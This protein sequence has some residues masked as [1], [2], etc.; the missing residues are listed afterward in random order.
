MN[1]WCKCQDFSA[2]LLYESILSIDSR[3]YYNFLVLNS[4]VCV[5]MVFA[6]IQIETNLQSISCRRA[7]KTS[8]MAA[9]YYG[10]KVQSGITIV[11]IYVDCWWQA[12]IAWAI[13]TKN[14]N[15]CNFVFFFKSWWE[16]LDVVLFNHFHVM[17]HFRR[18]LDAAKS[19]LFCRLH[20]VSIDVLES[21]MGLRWF[22][23]VLDV[24]GN[25]C[26][27]APQKTVEETEKRP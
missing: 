16:I 8:V 22:W 9:A 25:V 10:H 6:F 11:K 23:T 1:G 20:S 18:N 19:I 15:S 7:L 14:S 3:C 4:S 5:R 24:T 27:D 26:S 17:N 13:R 2:V 12:I 21:V